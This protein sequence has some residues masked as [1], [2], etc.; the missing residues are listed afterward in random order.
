MARLRRVG[1]CLA[2]VLVA[3]VGTPL[4][5]PAS[6]AGASIDRT[7]SARYADQVVPRGF[8]TVL[9]RPPSAASR[10]Y[11]LPRVLE[12]PNADAFAFALM[13]TDEYRTGAGR[14]GNAAVVDQ[15]YR[16]AAGRPATAGEVAIW[17][18]GFAN[19]SQNRATFF[20]WLVDH[21]FGAALTRPKAVVDCAGFHGGGLPAKCEAGSRG[22]QRDVSILLVPG[23]NIYV[24]RVW[25]QEVDALV[26]AARA[27]GW[28]LQAE[29]DPTVPSWMLS[30]GSWRS[31]D[32]QQWLYD[33]GFPANPPGRSLHEWGLAVDLTCN[34]VQAQKLRPCW[35]WLRQV[36]PGLHVHLFRGV[37]SPAQSEAWHFS[38]TGA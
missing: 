32:E 15:G 27:K 36:G 25:Y 21:Q 17:L 13:G 33:H 30:P 37:T 5:G 3:V 16:R 22:T 19:R 12:A 35:D 7:A 23:T 10:A 38:T 8:A 4:A 11:W 20:G 34:G 6:P 29:R 26:R 18:A 14:L 31:W 1:W 2:A 9:G 28:D 24:N